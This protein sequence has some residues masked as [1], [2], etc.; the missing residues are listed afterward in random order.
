MKPMPFS[1][2]KE[3]NEGW[4]CSAGLRLAQVNVSLFALFVGEE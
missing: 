1:P 4:G 2:Q 3:V